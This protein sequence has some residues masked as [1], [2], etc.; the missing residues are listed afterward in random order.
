M[1]GAIADRLRRMVAELLRRREPAADRAGFLRARF[2]TGLAWVPTR[3]QPGI[4]DIDETARKCTL[5][6]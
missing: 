5:P 4:E 1:P 6:V 3:R 2:D